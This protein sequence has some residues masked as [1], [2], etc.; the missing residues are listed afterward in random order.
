MSRSEGNVFIYELITAPCFGLSWSTSKTFH[1]PETPSGC[2]CVCVCVCI[3]VCVVELGTPEI[4]AANER[5][6]VESSAGYSRD[7]R[8]RGLDPRGCWGPGCPHLTPTSSFLL[9]I[10]SQQYFCLKRPGRGSQM[11][12]RQSGVKAT[13]GGSL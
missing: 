10:S 2:V 4:S 7:A 12:K 8:R 5:N 1:T 13:T 11:F 6:R 3:C 9:L